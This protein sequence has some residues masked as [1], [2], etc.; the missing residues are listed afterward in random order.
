MKAFTVLTVL[1]V[2]AVNAAP[3]RI[4][5][6]PRD[7]DCS[8][9]STST[10]LITDIETIT[11]PEGTKTITTEQTITL[12]DTGTSTILITD[13]DTIILPDE[14]TTISTEQTITEI[15]SLQSTTPES[16]G[17]TFFHTVSSS[18][19]TPSVSVST[20][21]TN[22]GTNSGTAQ[23]LPTLN[24]LTPATS[25][26]V[27][28]S[29]FTTATAGPLLST[30]ISLPATIISVT[31]PA[32]A[33]ASTVTAM[34]ASDDIFQPVETNAPP[35]VIGS[36]PDHPVP[37]LGIKSQDKPIETNKFYANFFLGSQTAAS[38]THPYSV[39]WS[40][41]G[42][43]SAS[44]G[45]S[46]QH[47]DADQRIF[48]PDPTAN[49]V[50]YF[51]NPIGIQSIVLSALELGASTTISTD[52]IT[53]FSANVNLLASPGADPSITFPLVQ[54][55]G[56]VTGIY[57]GGTPILQTGVLF[58]S[59]MMAATQPKPGVT[60]YTILLGDGT[61]WLLYAYSPAGMALELTVVNNELVQATSN[62]NGFIQI[63][64]STDQTSEALYDSRCGAYP[65][66]AALSG[67]VDGTTGSYTI[68]FGKAGL[69][70][71]TLAMFALPHHVESFS[72]ATAA[73]LTS[74]QLNTTTKGVA[75]AI[76]A[77][78]WTLVENLPTTMGFGPWSPTILG[79]QDSFSADTIAT[80][81][82]IAT[83]EVSQNMGQQTDLNSMYFSGK[84]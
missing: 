49:P 26:I 32:T 12:P 65:I 77:D 50:E 19:V 30:S 15:G 11:L 18:T 71:T 57:N 43:S 13:I 25:G 81:H 73:T 60:K 38:W 2:L 1:Q 24:T 56:F 31:A 63:A 14:T 59:I 66:T 68:A 76:V 47:I 55:M 53:A 78:S 7:L 41:G 69:N 8:S 83:S 64:K 75:T 46:I 44:W 79:A 35:S 45:I 34:I 80:I 27:L 42:G 58:T 39:A 6:F 70:D 20:I 36:R 37:R 21:A 51:I 29:L 5:R 67:S 9:T 54:G 22:S 40:K 28:T 17:G 16:S 52:A 3:H 4:G 33:P 82:S 62:F 84:V 10:I 48:G 23:I 74:V 61:T 72:S